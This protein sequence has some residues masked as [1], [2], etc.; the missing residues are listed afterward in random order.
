MQES[1]FTQWFSVWF[2]AAALAAVLL[3]CAG[4][5]ITRAAATGKACSTP[6]M[7]QSLGL[8]TALKATGPH[9]DLGNH[10]SV[11]AAE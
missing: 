10:V 7:E 2:V 5:S 1:T 9:P 6:D 8:V 4:L 3:S 11:I